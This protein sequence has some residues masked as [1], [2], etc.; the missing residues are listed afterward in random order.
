MS[1]I[2]SS[3]GLYRYRLARD[4]YRPGPVAAVFMVNPST[5]DASVN[6]PTIT[7]LLGFG[8]RLGWHSLIVGNVCAY[9][10]TKVRELATCGDPVGPDNEHHVRQIM[11]DADIHIAAWG[12]VAK[13]PRE[14]RERWRMVADCAADEGFDLMCWGT[15]QDGHPRHPLMLA[16][17]TKLQPWS[18]K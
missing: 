13:L 18:M 8:A 1:A 4:F 16:Y 9:R 12:P 7:R 2:I 6:D 15:A 10:A 11:R 3:C 17:D 5:A 14:H